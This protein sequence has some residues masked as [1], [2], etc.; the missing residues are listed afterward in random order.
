MQTEPRQHEREQSYVCVWY[1]SESY[2]PF[3]IK[4]ALYE[5]KAHYINT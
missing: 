2:G 4:Y 1:S 5:D 3:V